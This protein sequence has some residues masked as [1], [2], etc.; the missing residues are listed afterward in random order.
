LN[1][2]GPIGIRLQYRQWFE[3]P[4]RLMCGFCQLHL[5]LRF[6]RKPRGRD[7]DRVQQCKRIHCGRCV[8]MRKCLSSRFKVKARRDAG[9]SE[10]HEVFGARAGW[11][12]I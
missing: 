11:N 9:F 4:K 7:L 10:R 1:D 6:G 8:C 5:I 12:G 2:S 3:F